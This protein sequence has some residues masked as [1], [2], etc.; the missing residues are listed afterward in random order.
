MFPSISL[1]FSNRQWRRMEG[2]ESILHRTGKQKMN[3]SCPWYK[4]NSKQAAGRSKLETGERKKKKWIKK[5]KNKKGKKGRKANKCII[6][7]ANRLE[8]SFGFSIGKWHDVCLGGGSHSWERLT[9]A[10]Q[11]SET[12]GSSAEKGREWIHPSLIH[13]PGMWK[14]NLKHQQESAE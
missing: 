5:K 13:L 10:A 2:G 12:A 9:A 7:T 6:K 1:Y 3:F 14:Q 8:I 4:L 11:P